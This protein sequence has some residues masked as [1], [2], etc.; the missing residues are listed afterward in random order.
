MSCSV[1]AFSSKSRWITAANWSSVSNTEKSRAG[2]KFEGST[3]RP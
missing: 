3:M 1:G 2:K